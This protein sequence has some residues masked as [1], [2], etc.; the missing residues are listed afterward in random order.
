MG[1]CQVR[2]CRWHGHWCHDVW[3]RDKWLR[4]MVWLT[5]T[6][7]HYL[8]HYHITTL[9]NITL[10]LVVGGGE[11]HTAQQ[12]HLTPHW[13][14]SRIFALQVWRRGGGKHVI[15]QI[16]FVVI[17]SNKRV[18]IL[19]SGRLLCSDVLFSLTVS[20]SLWRLWRAS[21]HLYFEAFVS[22]RNIADFWSRLHMRE[23]CSYSFNYF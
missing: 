12:I 4:T 21:I 7:W 2:W 16:V 5:E 9:H 13:T 23:L 19:A 20:Q 22:T 14:L 8:A 15:S 11:G 18:E 10:Q 6:E 1:R 17:T 3:E